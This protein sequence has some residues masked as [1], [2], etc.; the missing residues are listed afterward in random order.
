MHVPAIGRSTSREGG[1]KSR[2]EKEATRSTTIDGA[3]PSWDG[4]T[5]S[6]RPNGA[7]P[8]LL[9][10]SFSLHFGFIFSLLL[11]PIEVLLLSLQ[12][13]RSSPRTHFLHSQH[14]HSSIARSSQSPPPRASSP[15]LARTTSFHCALGELT[16]EAYQVYS[17][18]LR[19]QHTTYSPVCRRSGLPTEPT[20]AGPSTHPW[21]ANEHQ[22]RPHELRCLDC[23]LRR[24]L[25]LPSFGSPL[26]PVIYNL[27]LSAFPFLPVAHRPLPPR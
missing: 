23:D 17:T 7:S 20:R 5:G 6:F 8:L 18:T 19:P 16:S 9:R 25:H 27:L 14:P 15:D 4:P 1:V 22:K 11:F 12:S 21:V 24:G 2:T 13:F 26:L 10:E 3:I